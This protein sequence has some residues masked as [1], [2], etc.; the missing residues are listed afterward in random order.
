MVQGRL[1][2]VALGEA[3]GIQNAVDVGGLVQLEPPG[4]AIS[5]DLNSN[6]DLWVA[7]D[8][9]VEHFLKGGNE[10]RQS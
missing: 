2:R 1:F 6:N 8:G 5:D 10:L 9:D 3:K 4:F 7:L